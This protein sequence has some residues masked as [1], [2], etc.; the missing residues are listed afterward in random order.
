MIESISLEKYRGYSRFN[1]GLSPHAFLVG[2]N[3]AGKSTI[4]EALAVAEK[5]LSI[6]RRRKPSEKIK[7][8]NGVRA[9]YAIPI[10]NDSGQ[11]DP[12]RFDFGSAEA[13]VS[14][15]WTTGAIIN[16]VWPADD[17]YGSTQ[18]LF[19]LENAS[20]GQVRSRDIESLF[21]PIYVVPVITPL[22][23]VEDLKSVQYV[24]DRGRT[25]LASRHFRN[26][27]LL[28]ARDGE[29][30]EFKHFIESWLLEM[31]IEEV[32]FT[33]AIDRLSV[34][35]L[36][37]QSRVPKEIAWAGDGLQ[38]W[39]QLLWHLY[40]AQSFPTIVLDEPEVYLHPDLQRRLVRLLEDLG[41][42][43]IMASHSSEVITEA[44]PDSVVWV[45]RTT[46]V[47]R[48]V[49]A[50]KMASS[51]G[52]ALGSNY[53]ISLVKTLRSRL[54]L[55]IEGTSV[56]T[57]RALAKAVGAPSIATETGISIIR[58]QTF[59]NWA[60][61]DP[62]IWI[63]KDILNDLSQLAV[64]LNMDLRPAKYNEELVS[65]LEAQGIYAHVWSKRELSNTLLTAPLIAKTSGASTFA[66][67]EH[68]EQAFDLSRT[69]AQEF[70]LAQARRFGRESATADLVR[71]FGSLWSLPAS[72]HNLASPA[73]VL[74]EL[75]KWL[76]KDGYREVSTDSLA[77]RADAGDLPIEVV[78]VL[79]SVER[80]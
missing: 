77:R 63:A 45:D 24:K 36:E 56:R 35:Y 76:A 13:R 80:L 68:L 28:M 6:A 16:M 38:I 37:P 26:N 52:D 75:N 44:T 60:S 47:G 66:V 67:E 65:T 21:S 5:C 29:L 8:P 22:E 72:K 49:G 61:P 62:L 3:S 23:H 27:L 20:G 69:E 70:W 40:K 57:L 14:I 33:S 55:A 53:S 71:E 39:L 42:Q 10:S 78:S 4:V 2:P 17:D 15:A 11:G 34:F 48:R 25:R 19:W 73:M 50:S 64:L 54:V 74:E 32:D 18:G 79:G 1:T 58:I 7:T 46:R 12:V 41:S 30:D 31:Q 59:S 51:L 43:I 9:G